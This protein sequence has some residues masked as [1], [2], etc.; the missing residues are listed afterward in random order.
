MHLQYCIKR[1]R[2]VSSVQSLRTTPLFDKLLNLE[3]T[4]LL[5][6]LETELWV[7]VLDQ[8]YALVGAQR[9][10][11]EPWALQSLLFHI[12]FIDLVGREAIWSFALP[13]M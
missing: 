7:S 11:E 1:D 10:C 9:Q 8:T 2:K 12:N 4:P 13:I 6:N 3:D 5:L